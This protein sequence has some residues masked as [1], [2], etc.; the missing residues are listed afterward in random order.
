MT[1]Q[2]KRRKIEQLICASFLKQDPTGTNTRYWKERFKGMSD[3]QFSTF[4]KTLEKDDEFIRYE[5][6]E[7]GDDAPTLENAIEASKVIGFDL[8][9]YCYLPHIT[10]DTE[11]IMRTPNKVLVGW[12]NLKLVQQ[13]VEKKNGVSTSINIRD[14]K[15]GQ[16]TSTDKNAGNSDMEACMILAYMNTDQ[17]SMILKEL[18]GFRSDDFVAKSEAYTS[19]QDKGY[20]S[21]DEITTDDN[22]GKMTLNLVNTYL[23]GC[24]IKSDLITESYV[25]PSSLGKKK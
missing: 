11:I 23:L 19:I 20:V 1:L 15:T 24:M 16:V 5:Y 14:P 22:T 4:M 17:E 2:E 9:Q 10:G 7:F 13:F 3:A 21:L 18:H 25:L 12:I 8:F 6:H